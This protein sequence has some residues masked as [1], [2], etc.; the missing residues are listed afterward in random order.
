MT[1]NKT[2]NRK[3]ALKAMAAL[4]TVF[5]MVTACT[6]GPAAPPATNAPTTAAVSGTTGDGREMNGNMYLTGLPIVKE[7]ETLTMLITYSGNNADPNEMGVHKKLEEKTNVKI[8]YDF[9]LSAAAKER[10]ATMFASGDYTDMVGGSILNDADVNTYGSQGVLIPLD[11]LIDKYMPRLKQILNDSP[12]ARRQIVSSN[13]NIHAMPILNYRSCWPDPDH[14]AVPTWNI[15][16]IWLQNLNMQIPTTIDELTQVLKAFKT[17]DPNKNGIADEIPMTMEYNAINR[18]IRT[19]LYPAFGFS[20]YDKHIDV[21]NGKVVYT[22]MLPEYK[23]AIKYMRYLYQ[24]GLIDQ[25]SFTQDRAKLTAKIAQ[26][27]PTI[28]GI[29]SAFGGYQEAGSDRILEEFDDI[30]PLL[31]PAGVR[32]WGRQN[33]GVTRNALAITSSCKKPEL[34]ARWADELYEP[35]MSV[36]LEYGMLGKQTAKTADGKY[37]QVDPPEGINIEEWLRTDT[38]RV[39]PH[40]VIKADD[41][42]LNKDS[43]TKLNKSLKYVNYVDPEIFPPVFMKEDE[44]SELARLETSLNAL[45]DQKTAE[46]ITGQA[47]IDAEWDKFQQELKQLGVE[48]MLTIRQ[49]AMDRY[50]S[51]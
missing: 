15:N 47:D 39:L 14:Y 16:K 46:W 43:T 37:Q 28:V 4:V 50:N 35:E 33:S 3:K 32:S 25:E 44:T 45:T 2:K 17:Q 41:V 26:T 13:G 1:G 19:C 9:V 6:A 10:K 20:D 27:D 22:A 40:A 34:A 21:I 7:K 30:L 24:E 5:I 31:G 18:S 49:Q 48:R 12:D 51:N 38:T 23:E 11:D 8:I 42:L 29:F 36:E